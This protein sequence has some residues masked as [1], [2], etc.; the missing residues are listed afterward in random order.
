MHLFTESL[1]DVVRFMLIQA[2]NSETAKCAKLKIKDKQALEILYDHSYK[3][4]SICAHIVIQGSRILIKLPSGL[5]YSYDLDQC[6]SFSSKMERVVIR[7]LQH[8]A[9]AA[10][11][12]KIG[13]IQRRRL[14]RDQ[15]L[16]KSHSSSADSLAIISSRGFLGRR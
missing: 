13:T 9:S 16:A 11:N 1:T 12:L 2:I 3:F 7:D 15:H 5:V 6:D 10:I 4:E 14:H 8:I